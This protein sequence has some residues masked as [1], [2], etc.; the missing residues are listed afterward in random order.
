MKILKRATQYTTTTFYS[1]TSRGYFKKFSIGSKSCFFSTSSEEPELMH[2]MNYLD[3]LKN[4]EKSGVPK[5]AGT[6]S[7]D[8]FDL[9][10]MNRLMDRLGNPH[11]KFKVRSF[12]YFLF[13]LLKIS[14]A[15]KLLKLNI[16]E[17]SWVQGSFFCCSLSS[18]AGNF[19]VL[20]WILCSQVA[21]VNA[22]CRKH[23]QL[24]GLYIEAPKKPFWRRINF[25]S[26]LLHSKML[27][28][29]KCFS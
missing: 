9:G 28:S 1:P 25:Y 12:C 26:Y 11:S 15:L 24:K 16:I 3:S 13:S 14:D 29:V 27:L 2:F 18:K 23:F 6:D 20:F 17:W 7:D 22:F 5:G 4:F 21:F 19:V 10:R 8:G